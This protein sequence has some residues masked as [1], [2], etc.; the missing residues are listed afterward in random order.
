[1]G[2]G[3]S[4]RFVVVAGGDTTGPA[5]PLDTAHRDKAVAIDVAMDKAASCG[6]E[7]LLGRTESR[8]NTS[9]GTVALVHIPAQALECVCA[10]V[11]DVVHTTLWNA[12]R[13][14]GH[15]CVS[16]PRTASRRPRRFLDRPVMAR[17]SSVWRTGTSGT[18]CQHAGPGSATRAATI[19]GHLAARHLSAENHSGGQR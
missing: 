14:A 18:S 4:D 3:M 13:K 10:T 8:D 9:A 15:E 5:A 19:F 11:D 7:A 12:F 17:P 6:Q 2:G 16:V 1:M